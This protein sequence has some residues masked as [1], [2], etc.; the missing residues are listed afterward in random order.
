MG[1]G[2][3]SCD[4]TIFVG[5]H[6]RNFRLGKPSGPDLDEGPH[7]S[8]THFVKEP[9]PF[10]NE[11]EERSGT[12]HFATRQSP[13]SVFQVIPPIGRKGAKVVSTQKQLR[14]MTNRR[15]IQFAWDVPRPLPFEWIHHRMIP[16]KVAVLFPSRIEAGVKVRFRLFH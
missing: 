15:V 2:V 6:F 12:L 4:R 5:Q 7:D 13:H 8:A 3:H 9:V 11:S 14:G 1:R 10:D 16:D